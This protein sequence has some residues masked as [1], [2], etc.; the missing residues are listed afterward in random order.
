LA[1][2]RFRREA[3]T[4]SELNHPHICTIY[5]IDEHEGQPFLVMELL[6]GQMLKHRISAKPLAADELLELASQ[7]AD[8]LD[9]AHAK[10]IVHRD[11]KPA[12]IFVTERGQVKVLDF[13]LA[14]LLGPKRPVVVGSEPA[15]TASEEELLS[16]P[17]AVVGTVAYMSPEQARGEN[18]DARTDLFSFGV[19]LYEMATGL[20]P[21]QGST[22][23]VLFEAILNRTPVPPRQLNP[24]LGVDLEH[25]IN[26]ALEKDRTKRYQ[27]ASD[28]RANL[29]RLKRDTDSGRTS[30]TSATVRG[31]GPSRRPRWVAGIAGGLLLALPF[32]WFILGLPPFDRHNKGPAETQTP[33][34]PRE[35]VGVPRVTPFLAGG[36]I[37]KKPAWSPA[38]DLI[39]F[40]SDEAGN[41]DIWIC[42]PSGANLL[43]LTANCKEGDLNPAWSPDGQR[44]AFYSERDGGG[45]FTMSVLGGDVRKLVAVK[46]GILYTFSLHWA[47]NG[48]IV[49][50]NFDAA[51]RKQIYR[52]TESNPNPECL[53]ARVG[54]PDG[55]FGELSPSGDL[56]V[57][58]SPVTALEATVFIG[59]LQSGDFQVI[60]HGVGRPHWGPRGDRIFFVSKRDGLADLWAVD[61]DPRTGAKKANAKRITS[62]LGIGEFTFGPDGRKLLAV[63]AKSQSQLWSFPTNLECL[64]ARD[65]GRPL[66]ANGFFDSTPCP[67]PDGLALLFTSNRRGNEDIWRLSFGAANPK[68]LTTGS[69]NARSPKVAPDG[70]WIAFS[71]LNEQGNYIHLMRP[72]GS[73]VH[74]LAP[75][76]REEFTYVGVDNWSPDS[77]RLGGWFKSR[78]G[79]WQMGIAAIDAETG[80]ARAIKLLDLPG[81]GAD[82]P[83]WS[84]DCRFFVY[85]AISEGSWDLWIATAEGTDPRR[86]TSDP[87][88]ERGP[89]WSAD[90]KFVY[91]VKDWRSI[92]RIPMNASG[93]QAGPAQ[94]WAQFPKTRFVTDSLAFTKD[95]AIIALTEGASDLWLVEFPEN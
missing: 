14:K 18:L 55:H 72:D 84:P 41:D 37:R 8:A 25:V 52:I 12:N 51:G 90:G 45:I 43:N 82:R 48:Q 50:T 69:G 59:S 47:K 28:L 86:L 40:V 19:V 81:W 9:A 13:G 11:I 68:R 27:T 73:N 33:F 31:A 64:T 63:K 77:S 32:G 39:A 53:T 62:G 70:Q 17:G 21:F 10:G 16:S 75:W 29:K 80:T 23:A 78:D 54:A 94:L 2:E 76:L 49:Y 71:L 4:A 6:E 66:L 1:L 26:K 30:A 15:P 38:G 44:I 61:V 34:V 57:F 89:V 93:E 83:S 95:Q 56:L 87:G 92:W 74:L 36:A 79:E 91:Y 65:A 60:E 24:T 35:V 58:L 20:R 85:Q 5:D 3:R 67:T 7:I 88:N 42:D 22:S 46:P